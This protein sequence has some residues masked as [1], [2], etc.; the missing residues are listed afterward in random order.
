M[1]GLVAKGRVSLG[2]ECSRPIGRLSQKRLI[3]TRAADFEMRPGTLEG[4]GGRTGVRS[5]Q[6]GTYMVF[7][8]ISGKRACRSPCCVPQELDH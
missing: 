8:A 5:M 6:N 7:R 2:L 3:K 1:V 4:R